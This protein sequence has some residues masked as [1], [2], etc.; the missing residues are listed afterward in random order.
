MTGTLAAVCTFYALG[1]Q[2]IALSDLATLGATAPIFVAL[3]SRPLLSEPVEGWVTFAVGLGFAGVVA[4]VRPSFSLAIPV[5][6]IATIWRRLL[7][8]GDDLAAQDR[9]RREP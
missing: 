9:A 6:L 3:L 2:R 1:S 5:A 7:R 4:V 8:T